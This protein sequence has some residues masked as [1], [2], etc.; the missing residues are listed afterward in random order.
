MTTHP[1]TDVSVVVR[2]MLHEER[3]MRANTVTTAS[4]TV[5]S[6]SAIRK[7]ASEPWQHKHKPSPTRQ[8]VFSRTPSLLPVTP[9]KFPRRIALCRALCSL[10]LRRPCH[11]THAALTCLCWQRCRCLVR[12]ACSRSS[13]LRTC[14]H[15]ATQN[16]KRP[17]PKHPP[18][19][20]RPDSPRMPSHNPRL[21]PAPPALSPLLRRRASHAPPSH[22]PPHA[23]LS[24]RHAHPSPGRIRLARTP[25]RALP[26]PA[27][28]TPLPR[29]PRPLT[30]L[31]RHRCRCHVRASCH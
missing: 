10:L 14:P 13:P 3:P 30:C 5:P 6:R 12:A 9:A 31:R 17:P 18:V 19:S 29:L 1:C 16:P 8:A 21:A 4:R 27:A 24:H 7:R 2:D 11:D 15:P 25:A 26:R 22:T 20:R 28:T 23:E